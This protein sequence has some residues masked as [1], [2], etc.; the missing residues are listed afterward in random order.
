MARW[1]PDPS[2]YASPGQAAR[3]P[4]ETL[5]YVA[6][7][8]TGGNGDRAPDALTVLDLEPGSPTYGQ[9]VGRLDMP[10]IGDELHHFGWN[11]CS[12]GAV[13]VGA[14][15]PRRAPLP[16]RARPALARRSTSST[17]RTTRAR[18]RS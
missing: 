5:A 4:P 7:L 15:P 13:P 1:T 14:P 10:G 16:A 11:A 18:P 8:N 12:S 9:L 6:T 2:F 3:A 17:S